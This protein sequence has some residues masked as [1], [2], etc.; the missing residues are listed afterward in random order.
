MEKLINPSIPIKSNLKATIVK[1]S[2]IK[3]GNK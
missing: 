2:N 3:A 1:E